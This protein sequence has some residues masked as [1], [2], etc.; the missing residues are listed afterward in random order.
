VNSVKKTPA[1]IVRRIRSRGFT[2]VELLIVTV[3]IGILAGMMMLMVSAAADSATVTKLTNDLRHLKNASFQY[4]VEHGQ[5]PGDDLTPDPDGY[6]SIAQSLDVYFDKSLSYA[7]DGKVYIS[8]PSN[9]RLYYGLSPNPGNT[10]YNNPN[11]LKRIEKSGAVYG[12]DGDLFKS[13]GTVPNIGP[14]YMVV[15]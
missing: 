14:F 9:G 3:I 15:K 2:L 4:F 5:F 13:D 6:E 12:A 8:K 11:V 1:I 7:Y 10:F